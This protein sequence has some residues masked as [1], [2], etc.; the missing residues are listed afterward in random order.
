MV[1]KC[2]PSRSKS[3]TNLSLSLSLS[4]RACVCVCVRRLT[5][6]T[7]LADT[8]QH[9]CLAQFFLFCVCKEGGIGVY[10]CVPPPPHTHTNRQ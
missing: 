3:R 6:I 10:V 4:L 1:Q 5:G 2:A 7:S 8:Y 9:A